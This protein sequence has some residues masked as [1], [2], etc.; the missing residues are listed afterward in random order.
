MDERRVGTSLRPSAASSAATCRVTPLLEKTKFFSD[1][2][3][4]KELVQLF[5]PRAT[6]Q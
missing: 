3:N 6:F 2:L 5:G 1:G 4:V